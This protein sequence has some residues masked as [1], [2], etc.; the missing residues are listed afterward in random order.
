MLRFFVALLLLIPLASRVSAEA[1]ETYHT[2]ITVHPS[3][4]LHITE[5]IAYDFGAQKRHGIFRDI[6]LTVKAGRTAPEVPIGLA[7][8][9]V[10]SD[11]KP[12]AYSQENIASKSGGKMIRY[13]IG[14]PHKTVTGKQNYSLEYDAQR[15]VFPSPY[16]DMDAIRWNAVGAGSDVPTRHAIADVILP[17]SLHRKQ[18]RIQVFTGEYGSTQSR[19]DYRWIDDHRIRFEVSKLAP[20]EALTV[21][22]NYPKGLLGQT[23]EALEST[24][25]DRLLGNWHWGGIVG[26]FLYLLSYA[27]RFGAE[28][29]AKSVAPQ[30]YPP[31]GLSLL[32]SGL[33]LD[34]FADK[35]DFSAA[36]LELGTLGYLEIHQP[37]DHADPIVRRTGKP[38]AIDDLSADQLYLL[39][40]ILFKNSDTY[41]IKT[42][43]AV[44]SERINTQLDLVNEMLYGW[45]VSDGQMQTNPKKTRRDFLMMV[46]AVGGVLIALALFSA[47]QTVGPDA[48]FLVP[49][50][51]LFIGIGG[52][53][54]IGAARQKAY[55]G[56]FFG[57]A[58]LGISL[59]GF[60]SFL[61]SLPNLSQLLTSSAILIPLIVGGIWYFYRRVGQFAPKGL[62][63]YRYLRGYSDF[64]K[65]V[66]QD[67]IRRF[68]AKDPHYLDRG[69]PYAVLF[70]HNK[71]WIGFYEALQI[72]Q[73]DWYYGDMHR[74]DDFSN[75]VENQGVAPASESGGFSGGGSFSGGGGGGGGVGSW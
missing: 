21:E 60:G 49:M 29:H 39:D 51:T 52:Y 65:R 45:S 5:V 42:Q 31:D 68:L 56:I 20:H 2:T 3:G 54:L 47:F 1:I 62:E 35:K 43:D 53:I 55:A 28:D 33:I 70:G 19:A 22:I 74:M 23:T 18:V 40:H 9:T 14:D 64:M 73:P 66:E 67:R 30:Y 61:A 37:D 13:R 27:R 57:V 17:P 4:G 69:L 46:G 12:L 59:V 44:R 71:H 6:P 8:F 24:W 48:A 7:N 75:S 36:I 41:L 63:T 58:W 34:K 15:G 10:K 72:P 26:F 11:G 38:T 32:Q 16:S 50:A 25:L